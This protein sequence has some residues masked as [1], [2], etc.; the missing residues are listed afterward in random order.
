MANP[1]LSETTLPAFDEI[2]IVHFE[3]ALDQV[4]ADNRRLIE[5]VLAQGA[6][7]WQGLFYPLEQANDCLNRVWSVIS[8]YNNV[9][10]S[11]V[12]RDIYK[13]LLSKLTQYQI[14]IGQNERLYQAYARLADSPEYVSAAAP[15][16]KA[17]ANML[18]DFKL[19]GVALN[20]QD[21]QQYAELS[22]TLSA[23]SNQFSENVLDATQGWS[24]HIVDVD[25]LRG[26]P[27]STLELLAS[28]AKEHGLTEGYRLTLDAPIY[29]PLMMH[30]DNRELRREAYQAY[31]TRASEQGPDAGKWDNTEVIQN[32][33]LARQ[34]LAKLLSF[35]H[36]AAYSLA[37]K[38]ADSVTEVNDFIEL[39]AKK[40]LGVAK[41]EFADLEAYAQQRDGLA[42]LEIWDVAYYSEK[43]RQQRFDVS[44][45]Q[46]RPYFPVSVVLNGLFQIVGKL[47]EVQIERCPEVKTYHPDVSYYRLSR[48]DEQGVP[49][50]FAGFYLDLYARKNKRGGAW[51]SDCR[52]RR[53]RTDGTIQQPVAFLTCNFT[54]PV[55]GKDSLLT[56]DE[57]TTLFHEFGHGLHHLLTRID[58]SEVSGISGVPWDV[59]ELPSQFLENWC[60]QEEAIGL[61][62]AHHETGAPLPSALLVKMLAAKHFQSA[63]QI[64]R[65]LEFALFDLVLHRDFKLTGETDV[66]ALLAQVRQQVSVKIP[67]DYTRFSHAFSHIFAGGYAAGY[68]SYKW[69]EVLAADAFSRFQEEGIFNTN[70]GREF[71]QKILEVGGSV[72]ALAMFVAFR[73]RKPSVDPLLIQSGITP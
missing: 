55:D 18:R 59:V 19:S 17:L 36:Y 47:F 44:Q 71:R 38:M 1:L 63:M 29:L 7:S 27:A 61:I 39:L 56:H 10:N 58:V 53:R 2:T 54:P 67:P 21:K 3:P 70:V 4:L 35:E 24:K 51:M 40:A 41:Q 15:Q 9:L 60:W 46:L 49:Q 72:D 45:E 25:E 52:V 12:L 26:V 14:E 31:A 65:Q 6:D 33:M 28:F 16:K 69:A 13:R 64:V 32:I 30:C 73:G 62:S 66:L 37:T 68:Y 22:Q 20:D 42:E 8:H 23:L 34:R 50:E 11:D 48:P 43:L 5:A 57:V